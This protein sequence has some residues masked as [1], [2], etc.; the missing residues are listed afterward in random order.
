MRQIQVELKIYSGRENPTFDL[1]WDQYVDTLS[2]MGDDISKWHTSSCLRLCRI[3][4]FTKR[5]WVI[6]WLFIMA[7]L[8][9]VRDD[10][11]NTYEDE[12]RS[13]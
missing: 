5:V 13:R 10:T 8:C 7:R 2:F 6:N 1:T 3:W 12:G 11:G 4:K 9:C